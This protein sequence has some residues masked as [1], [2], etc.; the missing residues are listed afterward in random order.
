M[1]GNF[2]MI[3]PARNLSR[4]IWIWNGR[5]PRCGLIEFEVW[6]VRLHRSP[7]WSAEYAD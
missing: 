1:V 3:P 2:S 7:V 5:E 6:D 4:E